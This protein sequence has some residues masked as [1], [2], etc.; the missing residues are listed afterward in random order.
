MISA[1]ATDTWAVAFLYYQSLIDLEHCNIE[2]T[3][4]SPYF[5]QHRNIVDYIMAGDPS[6]LELL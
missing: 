2:F 6:Q 3:K 4:K 5:G 1:P